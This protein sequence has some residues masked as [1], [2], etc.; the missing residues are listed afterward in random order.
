[1]RYELQDE[2][3]VVFIDRIEGAPEGGEGVDERNPEE[4]KELDTAKETASDDKEG[5]YMTRAKQPVEYY[6]HY[7][8]FERPNDRWIRENMVIINDELVDDL[9]EDFKKKEEKKKREREASTFL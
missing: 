4:Q 2:E 9:L 1:M 6:V 3:D 5:S 8:E 7:L